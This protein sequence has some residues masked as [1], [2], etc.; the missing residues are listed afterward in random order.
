[1]S[2][3]PQ[4]LEQHDK[5][6]NQITAQADAQP[7]ET[8]MSDGLSKVAIVGEEKMVVSDTSQLLD[9]HDEK[10]D[11]ITAQADAQPLDTDMGNGLSK[12]AVGAV[13]GAVVGILAG[14]LASK[15]TVHSINRTIKGVGD[16]VKGAA[17]GVNH[18]VKGAV[19]AAV[20]GTKEGGT[21]LHFTAKGAV[22][23]VKDIVEDA[24]PSINQGVIPSERQNFKLYEE[25]LVADKK[26]VKTASVSIRKYVETH[27]AHISVPLKKERLVVEQTTPVDAETP[28]APGEANFHEGEIARMEV[29][30]ETPDVQKLA[31]V[32]EEVNVR[33]EVAHNTVEVED[34]IRREELYLDSQDPKVI[35]KTKT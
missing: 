8:G 6:I 20:K 23:Q 17:Q 5:K 25:R 19:D 35:D 30:E 16:A 3:T 18:T 24:T 29:Y 9:R 15:R 4:L 7:V 34:K 27:T 1:M 10:V 22:D 11:Q 31:F 13:V 28:A 33:K 2:Q 14:A 26:Q 12:A 32:R 21:L